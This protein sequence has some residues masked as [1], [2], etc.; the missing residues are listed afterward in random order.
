MDER[1][2]SPKAA[3]GNVRTGAGKA[4]PRGRKTIISMAGIDG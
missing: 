3:N 1:N 4:N 2:V